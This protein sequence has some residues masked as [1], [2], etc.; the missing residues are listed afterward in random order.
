MN[1]LINEQTELQEKIDRMGYRTKTQIAMDALR[2]PE[3]EADVSK[4]SG[5]KRRVARASYY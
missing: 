1:N 2:V 3:P 5:E 4:P